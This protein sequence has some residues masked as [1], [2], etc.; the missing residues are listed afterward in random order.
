LLLL[1]CAYKMTPSNIEMISDGV[2]YTF[3]ELEFQYPE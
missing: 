3:T 1:K 2:I